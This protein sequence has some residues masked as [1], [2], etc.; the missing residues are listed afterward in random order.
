MFTVIGVALQGLSLHRGTVTLIED[1]LEQPA[2]V[3]I[4]HVKTAVVPGETLAVML[5]ADDEETLPVTVE[6]QTP[7]PEVAVLPVR[8]IELVGHV[9]FCAEGLALPFIVEFVGAAFTIIV[10]E[11]DDVSE[12]P[13]QVPLAS[14]SLHEIIQ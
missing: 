11:F 10:R 3:V 12:P 8:D 1:E 4:V 13:V 6:V 2:V 9:K 7:V 14:G 5:L